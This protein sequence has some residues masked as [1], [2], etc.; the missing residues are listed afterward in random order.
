[1]LKILPRALPLL[2]EGVEGE[3]ED[4]EEGMLGD[5]GRRDGGC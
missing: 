5:E 1:L 4:I 3:E 2:V